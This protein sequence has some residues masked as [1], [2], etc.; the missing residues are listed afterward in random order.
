MTHPANSASGITIAGSKV[1]MMALVRLSVEPTERSMP[2]LMATINWPSETISSAVIWLPMLPRFCAVK[3][4]DA[5]NESST[6]IDSGKATVTMPIPLRDVRENKRPI[7][8]RFLHA[9]GREPR[10]GQKS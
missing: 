10:S 7:T 4:L 1:T 8:L 2:P 9:P 3:K 5:V 6:N